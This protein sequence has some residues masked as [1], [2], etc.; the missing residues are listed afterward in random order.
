[1]PEELLHCYP[2]QVANMLYPTMFQVVSTLYP[3]MFQAMGS[4]YRGFSSFVCEERSAALGR[5]KNSGCVD[6][7]LTPGMFGRCAA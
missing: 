4:P 5:A 3:T 7:V 6:S 2:K 1:M